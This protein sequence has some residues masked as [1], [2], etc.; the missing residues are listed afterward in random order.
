[1]FLEQVQKQF[2]R[3]LLGG[4]KKKIDVSLLLLA[5]KV[6]DDNTWLINLR[7]AYLD[8]FKSGLGHSCTW[9]LLW[10]LLVTYMR[11]VWWFDI[12]LHCALAILFLKY[13]LC[14]ES[15]KPG[16]PVCRAAW[17]GACQTV[18]TQV[19]AREGASERVVW[20]HILSS[21]ILKWD[22]PTFFSVTHQPNPGPGH[23]FWDF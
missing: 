16:A 13:R 22:S 12:K 2:P 21:W 18:H 6:T 7:I 15:H 9:H 8:Q 20:A 14:G 19:G 5:F 4:K 3:V 10:M 17:A 11:L 1:M 23:L